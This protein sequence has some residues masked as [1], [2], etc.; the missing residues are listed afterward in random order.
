MTK[1]LP[2]FPAVQKWL[3]N[4][5]EID[6]KKALVE[7]MTGLKIPALV[8]RYVHLNALSA[9]KDLG[10]KV[11]RGVAIDLAMA[12]VSGES[13]HVVILEVKRADTYPWR[14]VSSLPNKQAVNK[15]V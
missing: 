3:E 5:A 1:R 4:E 12:Y 9:L 8:I 10:L 11:S 7:M 15:A 6:L 2:E 14:S 13:L